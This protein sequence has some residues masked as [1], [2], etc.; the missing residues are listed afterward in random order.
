METVRRRLQAIVAREN[1]FGVAS[2]ENLILRE[3]YLQTLKWAQ[4]YMEAIEDVWGGVLEL[5]EFGGL[6]LPEDTKDLLRNLESPGAFEKGSREAYSASLQP[7]MRG[8]ESHFK[9][10]ER[11]Q[12]DMVQKQTETNVLL[13]RGMQVQQGLSLVGF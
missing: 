3:R 11:G 2:R 12:R 7:Q 4:E 10:T 1:D 6:D 8:W 13:A 9:T 5:P